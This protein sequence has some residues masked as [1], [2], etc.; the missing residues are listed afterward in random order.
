MKSSSRLNMIQRSLISA[1]IT[2]LP[3][4]VIRRTAV[5]C[6]F[7]SK[8]IAGDVSRSTCFISER[9]EGI[10]INFRVRGHR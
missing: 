3:S 8:Q 10:F 2:S 1:I 6:V 5:S 9:F 7:S 4:H